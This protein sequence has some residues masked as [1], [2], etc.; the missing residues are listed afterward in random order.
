MIATVNRIVEKVRGFLSLSRRRG[1][2]VIL[3]VGDVEIEVLVGDIHTNRVSLNFRA[4]ECVRILRKEI[5]DRP[6][7]AA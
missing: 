3:R 1:E 7:R 4:P 5:A 6:L 2:S